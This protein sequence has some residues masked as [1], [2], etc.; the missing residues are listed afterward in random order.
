MATVLRNRQT[1][2][3]DRLGAQLDAPLRLIA[4]RSVRVWFNQDRLDQV[5]RDNVGICPHCELIYAIDSDGR[6]VSSNIRASHIDA[7]AFGQDLSRR[8]Y[9]V[10]LAVLSNAA[11]QGAFACDTYLSQVTH[12][13]CI[14]VLYGV[15]S[16]QTVLGFIAADFDPARLG[17]PPPAALTAGSTLPPSRATSRM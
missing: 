10:S 16:G 7:A 13:P 15:T 4:R 14:T 3:Y 17:L 8:P 2:D 1:V 12:R 6:Q 9:A 5:L 11:F